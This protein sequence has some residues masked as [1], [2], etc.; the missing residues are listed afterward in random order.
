MAIVPLTSR[1]F[2]VGHGFM[3]KSDLLP[4]QDTLTL[5]RVLTLKIV[6]KDRSGLLRVGS[7]EVELLLALQ[8]RWRD[9]KAFLY[10]STAQHSS[11]V[12][13]VLPRTR[14]IGLSCN[15]KRL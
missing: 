15:G 6:S 9:G 11:D 12:S 5:K 8:Y 10:S 1:S 3:V 4:I 7:T 2:R 13:K 14:L